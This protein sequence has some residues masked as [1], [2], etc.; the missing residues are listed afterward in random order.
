[1]MFCALALLLLV[2][3]R[4]LAQEEKLANAVPPAIPT[5]AEIMA[6]QDG[7]AVITVN[8]TDIPR[9]MYENSLRDG[10][11]KAKKEQGMT[12]DENAIKKAVVQ[13]LIDMEVLY[14]E[15]VD[16]GLQVN[17]AG[18]YLRSTIMGYRYRNDPG[19]FKQILAAAGMTEKQYAAIWQQQGA[20]NN[21]LSTKILANVAVSDEEIAA[22]YE[23]E[24]HTY[25]P[26]SSIRASHI[27]IMVKKGATQEEKDAARKKIEDVHKLA[28]SGE[29]FAELARKYTE[30]PNA[31]IGG[32]LGFFTRG[33]M[34]KPFANAAFALK[35]DEISPVVETQFGYHI[36]K[37]TG[38]Q[39]TIPTLEHMKNQLATT[40]KGEK[41]RAAFNEYK[42]ELMDDADIEIH[43]PALE[44]L[45]ET[46]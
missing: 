44:V 14:Q 1:M 29:D 25:T 45:Y 43:D 20:V 2:P 22:R 18:G 15:A 41:G 5:D 38:E 12:Y 23:Q 32:D 28:M 31:D 16:E 30:E 26:Q 9:W 46:R 13:N 6:K 7:T 42:A 35:I 3:T 40:I 17:E 36:I 27:L 24:K 11:R 34:V 10:I 39:E 8:D 37:K 33:E 4:A 21:L 19:K